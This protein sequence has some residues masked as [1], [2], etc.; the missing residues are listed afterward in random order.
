MISDDILRWTAWNMNCMWQV[1]ICLGKRAAVFPPQLLL[2]FKNKKKQWAVIKQNK[3]Q[4]VKF[5][6][7]MCPSCVHKMP[8]WDAG[9][10]Y[11]K[12]YV[13]PGKSVCLFVPMC[14]LY[15][16]FPEVYN[17]RWLG[18]LRRVWPLWPQN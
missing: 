12:F 16:H 5:R 14:V 4:A 11:K 10:N 9:G 13:D 3:Q 18:W 6:V 2:L 17:K 7:P 8:L 1:S 15:V